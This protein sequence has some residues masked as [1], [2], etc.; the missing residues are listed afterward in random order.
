MT[1][2]PLPDPG[3]PDARSATALLVWIGRRQW[4]LLLGGMV[5]GVIWMVALAVVPAALG[6]GI[7]AGLVTG[8][9][10]G[11]LVWSMAVTGLALVVA[12]AG[13][14]RHWFAV[15]N[16]LTATYRAAQIA[17]AAVIDRGSAVTRELPAGEVV[18]VF[19]NDVIRLGSVFDV[20]GRLMG[21][22]VSYAVVSL[23]L[24]SM[25]PQIGLVV[26]VGGPVM[27]AGLIV[28][29][30]PLQRRQ[31]EQ[32]EQAGRLT[33]LGADTVAGLR[34][35]RGIGG[36]NSF[37][38]RYCG[39]SQ[40]VRQA[41]VRVAG[42]QAALDS[43][44]ILVPGL[45]A[46]A[47]V[48]WGARL[49]VAGDLTPGQLVAFYGYA[50][51]LAMPLRT[52]AEAVDRTIRARIAARKILRI[53]AVRPDHADAEEGAADGIDI[54]GDLVDPL[55]GAIVAPGRLTAVVSD[56]PE[57]SAALAER[58]GRLGP[59]PHDVRFG[60]VRLRDLPLAEVRRRVV[61]SHADPHLF[62]GELREVLAP[63][64]SEAALHRALEVVSAQDVLE[65]LPGG[66]DAE[67]DE[68]GRSFSGGQ[69]QR[70]ALARALLTGAE[71]LVL[72]EPTSAVDAHT[73]ARIARQLAA[74]RRGRTTVVTTAS[75]LV[76]DHADHVV[77]L[78]DGVVAASGTHRD[79]LHDPAYRRVVHR[80]DEEG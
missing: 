74:H 41:G 63:G 29:V 59:G 75:P 67:V 36:E 61:V 13:A 56:R 7:D 24:V 19:A 31:A 34:V 73:E 62:T 66:L 48:W 28:I 27:L 1:T 18:A 79:L 57:D 68:R 39:Q 12:G 72:V 14:A 30:R 49:V 54:D 38:A 45:F 64:T 77:L 50:T 33:T 6:R 53:L 9:M 43:S 3:R 65:A 60:G 15:H 16:W 78:V 80:G 76:L 46:V 52:V 35:L 51:F 44:Q 70:L 47:V 10:S 71:V 55:S 11:L 2:F 8:D 40:Q 22:V 5:F 17:D 4:P 69:R 21:A 25:S 37:L 23:V 42:M 26:L 32:R 20:A 58:L